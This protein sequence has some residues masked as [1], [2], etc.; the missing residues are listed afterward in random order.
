MRPAV[1]TGCSFKVIKPDS[2][3]DGKTP[4]PSISVHLPTKWLIWYSMSPLTWSTDNFRDFERFKLSR[5][6]F[7]KWEYKLENPPGTAGRGG[8]AVTNVRCN[9]HQGSITSGYY[10]ASMTNRGN[11]AGAG[12]GHWR[13]SCR[14]LL[15]DV[16]HVC[17]PINDNSHW[18]Q[19]VGDRIQTCSA[20]FKVVLCTKLFLYSEVYCWSF[21]F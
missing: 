14:G 12:G 20:Y 13:A 6:L 8:A 17:L 18:Q 11:P 7:L 19:R 10:I 3:V 5:H 2:S 4:H 9:Y 15:H 1:L 21:Y 16:R